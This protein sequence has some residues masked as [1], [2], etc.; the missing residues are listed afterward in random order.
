MYIY[1]CVYTYAYIYIYIIAIPIFLK[2]GPNFWVI[3]PLGMVLSAD[4]QA[5]CCEPVAR[6]ALGRTEAG[7]VADGVPAQLRFRV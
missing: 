4:L 6:A 2:M 5:L 3:G 1:M 7:M